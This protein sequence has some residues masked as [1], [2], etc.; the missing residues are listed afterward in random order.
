MMVDSDSDA[1]HVAKYCQGGGSLEQLL[2]SVTQTD[3]AGVVAN[4]DAARKRKHSIIG[5]S[6]ATDIQALCVDETITKVERVDAMTDVELYRRPGPVQR[7]TNLRGSRARAHRSRNLKDTTSEAIQNHQVAEAIAALEA[8]GCANTRGEGQT[9]CAMSDSMNSKGNMQS[10]QASGDLPDVEIVEDISFGSDEGSAMIELAFDIAPNAT[11][12]FNTAFRGMEA[13][14]EDIVT[15]AGPDHSCDIIV[16]DVTYFSVT[17]FRDSE[18]A[19][20][21]DAAVKDHDVLYFSSAGN[22]GKAIDFTLD[23]ECSQDF[24]HDGESTT[25]S[26]CESGWATHVF[27]QSAED[28]FERYFF[29]IVNLSRKPVV[30]QW[31]EDD[32]KAR[33]MVINVWMFDEDTGELKLMEVGDE[34]TN[35]AWEFVYLPAAGPFYITLHQNQGPDTSS[36]YAQMVKDTKLPG[37][38]D[39][40]MYGHACASK[41]ISVAA[42]DRFFANGPSN[43]FEDPEYSIVEDFS[44]RGKCHVRKKA[45]KKLKQRKHPVTTASNGMSTSTEGFSSFYGTSASAPVAA[46][47]AALIRGACAP[48]RVVTRDDM[49]EMLTNY[50]YT[51]DYVSDAERAERKFG[52]DAGYGIISALKMTKW[53]EENC[54][55]TC[56]GEHP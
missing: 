8:L 31:D 11:Y 2:L 9:L 13:M 39:S 48:H 20:A 14:A 15:L 38:K 34:S 28:Y 22:F 33:D 7:K 51:I 36:V 53:V 41:A 4:G 45:S 40:A 26:P 35:D 52:V 19:K 49:M 42:I 12:K 54:P 18:I 17:S 21:V 47:I 27:D 16:D 5:S 3:S 37:A 1:S 43:E 55:Q 32:G 46:A 25:V 44:S 30:L 24:L 29:E 6:N 10:L 50:D 23:L 56:P